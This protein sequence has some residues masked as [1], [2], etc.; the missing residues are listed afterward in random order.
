MFILEKLE[1]AVAE[2][3]DASLAISGGSTPKMMF[4]AM[5][6]AE[7]DWSRVHVFWVD[8]RPVPPEHEQS[9]YRLAQEHL[10]GPA[11]IRHVHRIQAELP[12]D[13]AASGY[14]RELR[15]FF[16]LAERGLPQFDVIHLGIGSDAH[17][18][19]LFP[20]EPMIEDRD[21]LAAAVYVEK[22]GQWR[23]T[24]LPGVLLAARDVAVLAAGPDKQEAV[25]HILHG[26]FSPLDYPA[27][28][29]TR[30]TLPSAFFLDKASLS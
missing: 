13:H 30:R 27:Q 4:D 28:L 23:I 5:A 21:G 16:Q 12:P 7:F 26:M 6:A 22:L 14:S 11:Q 18:A 1:A 9:N 15:A 19:S 17:T 20:G 8:E 2:R 10:L 24:L 29:V 3:G 25:K